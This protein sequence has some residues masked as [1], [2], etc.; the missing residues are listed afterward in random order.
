MCHTNFA[1]FDSP[2]DWFQFYAHAFTTGGTVASVRSRDWV[3]DMSDTVRMTA[4]VGLTAVL[5]NLIRF[6]LSYVV[7]VAFVPGDKCEPGF[8]FGAGTSFL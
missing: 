7:P 5:K 4:G 8:Y 3:S 6:E 2:D 1:L